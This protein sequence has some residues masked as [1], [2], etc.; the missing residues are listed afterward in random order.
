MCDPI[1]LILHVN[2][3]LPTYIT[4]I[5]FCLI[6][7]IKE[8]YSEQLWISCCGAHISFNIPLNYHQTRTH[9]E[10]HFYAT[11]CL[12]RYSGKFRFLFFYTCAMSE[13]CENLHLPTFKIVNYK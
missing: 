8:P 9:H 6:R 1:S 10:I 2:R 4:T 12:R 5:F 7:G 11:D 3:Q 13:S